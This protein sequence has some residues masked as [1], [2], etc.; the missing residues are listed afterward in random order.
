MIVPG[1]APVVVCWMSHLGHRPGSVMLFPAV[2]QK[3]ALCGSGR[4]YGWICVVRVDAMGGYS[5]RGLLRP[6]LGYPF[7]K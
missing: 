2:L 6:R 5:T 1:V 3:A 4:R 7:G